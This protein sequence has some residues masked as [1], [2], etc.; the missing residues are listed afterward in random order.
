[1]RELTGLCHPEL[2][3]Q[4]T[5]GPFSNVQYLRDNREEINDVQRLLVDRKQ[6]NLLSTILRYLIFTFMTKCCSILNIVLVLFL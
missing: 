4:N 5:V 3:A 1:M 2:S 6:I